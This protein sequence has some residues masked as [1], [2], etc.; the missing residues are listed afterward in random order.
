MIKI[1]IADDQHLFRE[2]L[3]FI[4][5][6]EDDFEVLFDAENGQ[7][8]LQKIDTYGI[9][10]IVLMDVK[11]PVMDGMEAT[12]RLKELYPQVKVISISTYD[13]TDYVL[14]LLDLGVSGYLLK[15]ASGQDV[16]KAIRV[17]AEKGFY[18][19]DFVTQI[20]LKGLK[21]KTKTKPT[22]TND[23]KVTER[24][25]EILVLIMKE[26]TTKEIA[27]KIHISNRTVETHRKNLLEKFEVKNTV[28]LVI[29]ALEMGIFK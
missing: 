25:M 2:G 16:T 7:V 10:D 4:I 15:H 1:A 26:F 22:L 14:H 21:K 29:K 5:E 3:I 11:M 23:I 6:E 27:D 12:K 28:G 19:D 9:P 13:H 17:V 24:E 20:M 18:F 8:L